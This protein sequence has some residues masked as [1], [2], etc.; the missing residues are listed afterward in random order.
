MYSLSTYGR[1]LQDVVRRESYIEAMKRTIKPGM[2]VLEIGTG[3]GVFALFACQFSARKVYA[4]DP[5][6]SIQI[7]RELA[8][9]QG[10]ADRIQFIQDISTRVTLPEKVDLILSDLRGA[11]PL[12]ETHLPSIV[13]ARERFLVESGE[14]IP[15]SDKLW[16]SA[17]EAP[18][19]Y[20][21]HFSFW[22]DNDLG[23]STEP[24]LRILA[25]SLSRA[26]LQASAVIS[27][28]QRWIELDYKT[29]KEVSYGARLTSVITR[30][31]TAHGLAAWF[32]SE[33][34]QGV[35]FSTAPSPNESIYGQ[36]FFPWPAPVE[37]A[38]G[39]VID[40]ELHADLLFDNYVWRWNT[41]VKGG[42]NGDV[43]ASFRQS[44][45]FGI[46]LSLESLRKRASGFQPSLNVQGQVIYAILELMNE[47]MELGEIATLMVNRFPEQFGTRAEALAR[48]ADLSQKYSR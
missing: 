23:L 2:T 24:A 1:M 31:G 46:P 4:V 37:V 33:L 15:R 11:L 47:G 22:L 40:I 36:T 6:D 43:R 38:I 20:R 5:D 10:Y 19:L 7:G 12:F 8:L 25:N 39:D 48:I 21:E 13:D 17:V 28:P 44:S 14:L 41:V 32:D 27:E 35:A 34:A 26:N 45:C 29:V 16:V 42:G 30:E 18:D 9:K 3:P